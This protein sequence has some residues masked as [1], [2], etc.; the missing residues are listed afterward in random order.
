MEYIHIY[1]ESN[2]YLE[3]AHKV[4]PNEGKQ[5]LLTEEE[6]NRLLSYDSIGR[7]RMELLEEL[8]KR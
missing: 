6:Y 5:V 4:L 7:L 3:W 1:P 8:Y 2:Q